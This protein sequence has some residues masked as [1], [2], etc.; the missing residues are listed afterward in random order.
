MMPLKRPEYARVR[1][2]DIPE[3]IIKEYNLHDIA[4]GDGWLYL[5][6]M[7]GMY[8]LPQAGSL[9][10]DLLEERLNKEGYFQ[11]KVVPGLWKHIN[12]PTL[13]ALV[14]DNF[15]IKYMKEADL[16]HL[17]RT[18]RQYYNV[19]V[20]LEGKEYVK[21]ELDW[22]YDNGCVHLSMAPYLKKALAQF[23][24]ETPKKLQHS[25]YAFVPP[26]YDAK[27]QFV[28]HDTSAAATTEDQTLVQKV[29]GKFNWY[30]RAVDGTMLT[31]LSALAVNSKASQ[32]QRP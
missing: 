22:D 5:R 20:D 10:H 21:I 3:E 23:G 2:S 13:F 32:Q 18:L 8:G 12:R 29:T 27:V 31:P 14:V 6:V 26:K 9:G 11:S 15:G 28:E 16:D 17:I 1:L 4:T 30:A 24:V 19:S 25:P 7:R